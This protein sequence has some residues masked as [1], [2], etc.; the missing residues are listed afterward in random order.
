MSV[1]LNV[2]AGKRRE[3]VGEI[4]PQAGM[5]TN[6]GEITSVTEKG[7]VT[8][9]NDQGQVRL[10]PQS[11]SRLTITHTSAIKYGYPHTNGSVRHKVQ[12]IRRGSDTINA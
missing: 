7:T 4:S 3:K 5:V 12:Q 9:T 6:E 10:R 11:V 1:R 2:L 8:I